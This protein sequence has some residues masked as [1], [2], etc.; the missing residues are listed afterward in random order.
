MN[1]CTDNGECAD[2][3]LKPEPGMNDLQLGGL[4]VF[5]M[6]RGLSSAMKGHR[7]AGVSCDIHPTSL[8]AILGEARGIAVGPVVYAPNLCRT[9]S[10]PA[11]WSRAVDEAIAASCEPTP[12][13]TDP[14]PQ[15]TKACSIR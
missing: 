11:R 12:V 10:S 8:L 9:P 13:G 15:V 14:T 3:W 5:S 2:F 6:L 4:F 7:R 1:L